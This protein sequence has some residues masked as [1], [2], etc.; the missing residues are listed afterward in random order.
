MVVISLGGSIVAGESTDVE[1][2]KRF[3]KF[4]DDVPDKLF[5]VV[6]GGNTA[7]RYIETAKSLGY[8]EYLLDRIGIESTRLNAML[9]ITSK[10]AP[11]IPKTVDESIM[12]SKIY[13]NV[14]MGG[15]EPGHTTDGVALLLAERAG[16]KYVV[17]M[18]S[19][20]GIYDK[21]PKTHSDAKII[22]EMSYERAKSIITGK[23][24]DAGLNVPIDLLA[25]K[26]AE[27][28]NIKIYVI[29]KDL[30]NLM[31]VIKGED[32]KGTVIG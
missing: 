14:V 7:R 13:K 6:G 5:V 8:N 3:R 18:T 19:V 28:S 12:L 32:F 1:Y 30:E 2:I 15:T 9:L 29:G 11:K 26:I 10:T 4:M 21:D 17:N 23:R 24:M 22:R 20:G 27:R 16:E 31:R 25:L